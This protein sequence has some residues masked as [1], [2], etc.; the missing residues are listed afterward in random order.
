MATIQNRKAIYFNS[1]EERMND[2]PQ[3][4]LYYT[5]LFPTI[6]TLSSE[7]SVHHNEKTR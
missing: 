6:L 3:P 1:V 2:S 5:F 4:G 7:Y